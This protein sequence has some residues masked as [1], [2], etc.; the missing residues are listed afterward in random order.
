MSPMVFKSWGPTH[1]PSSRIFSHNV[2][3]KCKYFFS[4]KSMISDNHYTF[5]ID[6]INTQF[7]QLMLQRSTNCFV[8]RKMSGDK[9][10]KTSIFKFTC[11]RYKK[12]N[13]AK[14]NEGKER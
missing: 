14:S 6:A 12:K 9:K 10:A 3:M 2:L 13:K 1:N 7:T 11:N 5:M 4:I 8:W